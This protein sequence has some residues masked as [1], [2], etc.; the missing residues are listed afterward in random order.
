VTSK[1]SVR[2]CPSPATQDHHLDPSVRDDL[3]V[4]LCDSCHRK[5][6]SLFACGDHRTLTRR[7]LARAK[8]AGVVA[9]GVAF[10]RVRTNHVDAAGHRVVV[11]NPQARATVDRISSL[12]ASGAS[13]RSI[14]AALDAEGHKTQRGGPWK[15]GTV[16]KI[17][18][19][20]VATEAQS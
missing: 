14:C 1:C 12:R 5:A 19:R 20:T 9:G 18:R 13:M 16:L 15:P 6:H 10:G 17:L 8:N 11:E 7:G 4:P 3:I 2:G